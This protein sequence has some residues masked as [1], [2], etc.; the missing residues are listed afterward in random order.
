MVFSLIP[1][2]NPLGIFLDLGILSLA[3][4]FSRKMIFFL[5]LIYNINPTKADGILLGSG[6]VG[7]FR[8][9][10]VGSIVLLLHLDFFYTLIVASILVVLAEYAIMVCLSSFIWKVL[11]KRHP[12]INDWYAPGDSPRLFVP[13]EPPQKT[14]KARRSSLSCAVR[15]MGDIFFAFKHSAFALGTGPR[16]VQSPVGLV[17]VLYNFF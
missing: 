8:Y 3:Y 13:A 1:I 6:V 14:T 11:R 7:Y 5:L 15:T 2:P 10:V 4:P 16:A 12:R 9:L 17:R